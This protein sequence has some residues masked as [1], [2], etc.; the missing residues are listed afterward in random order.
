MG[1]VG[2]IAN[3]LKKVGGSGLIT[4]DL[5]EIAQAQK[6]IL[7]GVGAFDSGM[8]NLKRYDLIGTLNRQVLQQKIPILGICLGMQLMTNKSE[9]GKEPG[10]QWI[11][12][13][14][15]KFDLSKAAQ[16]LRVPHMGWNTVVKNKSHQIIDSIALE[17]SRFY[18]VHSYYIHC[19]QPE[20]ILL[21]CD[22]G[23]S[24]TAAFQK[25]NIFGVQFHTEKSHK[26]GMQLLKNFIDL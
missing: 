9:E 8:S 3:M 23:I 17:T 26:F 14:T 25:D 10:L 11:D 13:E 15:L 1:N 24:F 21:T 19:N 6:I 16:I 2:S 18:F 7:P 12:A 22:Y 5:H 4:S 20:D